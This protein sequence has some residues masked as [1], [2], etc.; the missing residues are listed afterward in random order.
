MEIR[1]ND[2]RLLGSWHGASKELMNPCQEQLM[3]SFLFWITSKY[4][5]LNIAILCG[6]NPGIHFNSIRFLFQI[7][8]NLHAQKYQSIKSL[9]IY[10][11]LWKVMSSGNSYKFMSI[12]NY[13]FDF[14]SGIQSISQS[15][16][17]EGQWL[18]TLLHR[19]KY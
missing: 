9:T 19:G 16:S 5:T 14:Q 4:Y 1:I 18:C 7:R 3:Q 12:I 10:S 15:T 11:L 13:W 17:T 2:T 6:E 8:W